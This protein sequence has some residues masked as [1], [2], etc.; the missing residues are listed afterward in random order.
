MHAFVLA[1][2]ELAHAVVDVSLS[3]GLRLVVAEPRL[4]P[5]FRELLVLFAREELLVGVFGRPPDYGSTKAISFVA[6]NHLISKGDPNALG[7]IQNFL[8]VGRRNNLL[9]ADIVVD[10]TANATRPVVDAVDLVR[11]GGTIVL[12]GLK[13]VA[14]DAFPSDKLVLRGITVIGARGVTAPA[15]RD[16]LDLIASERY[17]LDRL[18]TQVAGA[19]GITRLVQPSRWPLLRVA[20]KG[21]PV[22]AAQHLLRASGTPAPV[23]GQFDRD[24]AD[25]VRSFQRRHGIEVTGMIGGESWPLLARP[26][27]VGQDGDAG[28]AV[29]LLAARRTGHDGAAP[30]VVDQRSWQNLLS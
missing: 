6:W 20:D 27:R 10:V 21:V 25:A 2:L 14:V 16:A 18:R 7:K 15:Y 8:D 13:G 12:G 26:V 11:A 24:T 17:P 22:Q 19:L 30:V 9:S 5:S 3:A 29:R 1:Q 28:R 23:H 4:E